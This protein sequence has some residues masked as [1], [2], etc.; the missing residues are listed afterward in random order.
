M[1]MASRK[2]N[3]WMSL[4]LPLVWKLC[5]C[6]RRS[7]GRKIA[8]CCRTRPSWKKHFGNCPRPVTS[9]WGPGFTTD[10]P[11][12][13]TWRTPCLIECMRFAGGPGARAGT[14]GCPFGSLYEKRG[15]RGNL[16]AARGLCHALTGA[17]REIQLLTQGW[18]STTGW[19]LFD[20]EDKSAGS[21]IR[22]SGFKSQLYLFF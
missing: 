1:E 9:R 4:A 20:G 21:G 8:S 17:R 13:P 15:R 5:L 3:C 7:W 2:V 6:C 16:P 18:T 22:K 10:F 14:Q 11:A 19:F 12:P